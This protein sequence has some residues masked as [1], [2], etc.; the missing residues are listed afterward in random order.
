MAVPKFTRTRHFLVLDHSMYP[1]ACMLVLVVSKN[2]PTNPKA[3]LPAGWSGVIASSAST[4]PGTILHAMRSYGSTT[5]LSI[6]A[7]PHFRLQC[8]MG[9]PNAIFG[10]EV[11][12]PISLGCRKITSHW[13]MGNPPMV[14]VAYNVPPAYVPYRIKNIPGYDGMERYTMVGIAL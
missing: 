2:V 10:S 5:S 14:D 7:V 11:L 8:G 12:E 9:W 6:I 13:G 1:T 4:A 3:I